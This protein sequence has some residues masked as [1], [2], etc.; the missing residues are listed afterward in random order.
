MLEHRKMRKWAGRRRLSSGK[1]LTPKELREL[2]EWFTSMDE[3]GSGEIGL[4]ELADM[5]LTSGLASTANE[6]REIFD[7]ID[8]DGS[9]KP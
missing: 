6:V 1:G 5:L 4:E 3:D 7:R 2:L 8:I 9:G